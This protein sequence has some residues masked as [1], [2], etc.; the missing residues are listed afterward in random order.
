MKKVIKEEPIFDG[1]EDLGYGY[2]LFTFNTITKMEAFIQRRR[3]MYSMQEVYV[4]NGC[5]LEVFKLR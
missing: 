2:I 1:R 5:A 3:N 4:P